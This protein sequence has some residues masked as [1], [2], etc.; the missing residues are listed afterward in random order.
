MTA[1]LCY[2]PGVA[3]ANSLV[4]VPGDMT[5]L[6][7]HCSDGRF[8]NQCD[9]FVHR[10]LEQTLYDRLIVPGGAAWLA[11]RPGMESESDAARDALQLLVE[12][13]RL[14]RVV[15]IAHAGCA[16][17]Q[18]KLGVPPER[19]ESRQRADLLRACRWL[20]DR[21]PGVHVSAYYAL[22]R[23]FR[24]EFRPVFGA[25]D[26][27]SEVPFQPRR[28]APPAAGPPERAARPPTSLAACP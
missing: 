16:F 15:L 1:Q 17:Y 24:V 21:E 3:D 9:R 5:T 20:R 8:G 27:T 11:G 18:Q 23:G 25:P 12:V 14:S 19:C 28:L 2:V 13:H 7:V 10:R 22:R 6:V 26:D 4:A